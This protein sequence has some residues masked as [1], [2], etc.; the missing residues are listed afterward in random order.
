MTHPDGRPNPEPDRLVIGDADIDHSIPLDSPQDHR[1]PAGGALPAVGATP[2]GSA[3][4]PQAPSLLGNTS[5]TSGLI[6]G[7]VGGLAGGVIAEIVGVAD[8]VA[9]TEAGAKVQFG[10]HIGIVGAFIGFFLLAWEGFQAQSSERALQQGLVGAAIGGAA[11]FVAGWIGMH[12]TIAELEK[13]LDE[14]LDNRFMTEEEA[15]DRANSTFRL[16]FAVIFG[17]L[18][19]PVGGGIGV[20]MS[21]KKAVNG[22]VGGGIGGAASG[23]LALELMDPFASDGGS[24]TGEIILAFT[25]TGA[26]I[27]FGMGL[28]DRIRRDAWLLVSSGPMAGKEFILYKPVTDVGSDYRS[29]IVL[30]KDRSVRADHL[31]LRRDANG[32]VLTSV[33]D[34]P[35]AVND[36]PV[37]NHRLRPGDRITVGASTLQY[38]ERAA[39]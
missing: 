9:E 18:G 3:S 29:D 32:T 24:G 7:I 12:F 11:G 19:L 34:A 20:R 4:T 37:T 1:R 31:R 17:L 38:L 8:W 33:A 5:I 10:V 39:S 25:L 30:V 2:A 36:A 21:P 23:L 15:M 22:L 27:G 14:L 13:L 26:A 28:V 35:V 6:S 16:I